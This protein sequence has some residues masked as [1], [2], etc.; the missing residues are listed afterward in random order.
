MGKLKR[1]HPPKKKSIVVKGKERFRTAADAV[2]FRNELNTYLPEVG[3]LE[4]VQ[5]LAA[6]NTPKKDVMELFGLAE[7]TFDKHFGKAFQFGKMEKNLKVTRTLFDM[8]V[9]HEGI[10]DQKKRKWLVRPRSPDT[11]S[12][13]WWDKTRGGWAENQNLNVKGGKGM[14]TNM[15]SV[16]VFLPPNGREAGAGG[17]PSFV[18][19]ESQRIIDAKATRKTA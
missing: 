1:K 16:V 13:I 18:L 14:I 3:Q 8:A 4:T 9:G 7:D 5:L 19:R 12:M 11:T 10:Y 2:K 15:T 17:D 6:N